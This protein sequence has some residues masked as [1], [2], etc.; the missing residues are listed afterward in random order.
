[1]YGEEEEIVH[2][3]RS[4]LSLPTYQQCRT[5]PVSASGKTVLGRYRGQYFQYLWF[6]DSF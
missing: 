1:M 5:Y 6:S 3:L 4:T 2:S